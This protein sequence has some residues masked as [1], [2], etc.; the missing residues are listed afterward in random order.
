MFIRDA[1][2]GFT[3]GVSYVF[4]KASRGIAFAASHPLYTLTIL[5]YAQTVLARASQQSIMSTANASLALHPLQ[6]YLCGSHY[7]FSAEAAFG[8]W[9]N[10]ISSLVMDSPFFTN[11]TVI[12]VPPNVTFIQNGT[13]ITLQGNSSQLMLPSTFTVPNV[14]ESMSAIPVN[15][16]ITSEQGDSSVEGATRVPFSISQPH[17]VNGYPFPLVEEFTGSPNKTYNYVLSGV[18]GVPLVLSMPQFIPDEDP[19]PYISSISMSMQRRDQNGL[20]YV[21]LTI[22]YSII[23]VPYTNCDVFAD[24]FWPVICAASANIWPKNGAPFFYQADMMFSVNE[25]VPIS[26]VPMNRT[27]LFGQLQFT[28]LNQYP[29]GKPYGNQISVFANVNITLGNQIINLGKI[30]ARDLLTTLA[31]TKAYLNCSSPSSAKLTAQFYPRGYYDYKPELGLSNTISL[32]INTFPPIVPTMNVTQPLKCNDTLCTAEITVRPN[33]AEITSNAQLEITQTNLGVHQISGDPSQFNENNP[34]IL[35]AN[36]CDL[37]STQSFS[38]PN[39]AS[40]SSAG[41]IPK[42]LIAGL[43]VAGTLFFSVGYCLYK[44]RQARN[45]EP[46]QQLLLD[47]VEAGAFNQQKSSHS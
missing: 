23:R 40:A 10:G 1:L 29:S 13:T 21:N 25:T 43:S 47:G 26:S 4:R 15:Y 34:A 24:A 27:N 8:N 31:N 46:Q 39:D 6:G 44:K 30:N 14:D 28:N 32:P 11:E 2:S 5:L 35:T 41:S 18:S 20:S 38:K 3:S 22:P 42:G 16:T 37:N 9:S 45:H 17:S 19:D 33:M 36:A 7:T 12:D